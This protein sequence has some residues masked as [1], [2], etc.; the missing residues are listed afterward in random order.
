M[1]VFYGDESGTHGKGDYLISGYL[2]HRTTWDFFSDSWRQALAAPTPKPI[3]YLKM[4][5]WQHRYSS[6]RH[7]GQFLDWSDT[8][9]ELKLSHLIAVLGIFLKNGSLGEFQAS[10]SWDLYRSCVDGECLKVFDNPYYFN[11]GQITKQAVRTVKEKD[12]KFD[13]KIH[14]VF[15]AGNSAEKN[16]PKHFS[17][18]KKYAEPEIQKCIG[19]ISFADDKDEPALQIADMLAWHTR[20]RLAGIDTPDDVQSRNLDSLLNATRTYVRDMAQ[21]EPLRAHSKAVNEHLAQFKGHFFE[22]PSEE[23]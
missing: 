7:T 18:I 16:A 2:S 10:I 3:R 9:A 6:K 14:F 11:L 4:S 8:D 23:E 1:V 12:P 22:P 20:R 19:A 15:D 17:Y 5:E 21:E 13:G